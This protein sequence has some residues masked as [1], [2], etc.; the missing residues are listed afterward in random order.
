MF[1]LWVRE[2]VGGWIDFWELFSGPKLKR[3]VREPW[4]ILATTTEGDQEKMQSPSVMVN[5]IKYRLKDKKY[6][7]DTSQTDVIKHW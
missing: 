6:H 3:K 4:E 1:L 7:H 5:D 2:R